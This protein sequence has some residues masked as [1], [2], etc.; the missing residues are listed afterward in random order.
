VKEVTVLTNIKTRQGPLGADPRNHRKNLKTKK[1]PTGR[2]RGKKERENKLW[3]TGPGTNPESWSKRFD[4]G[5]PI[6]KSGEGKLSVPEFSLLGNLANP[7]QEHWRLRGVKMKREK[8]LAARTSAN[9]RREEGNCL[10]NAGPF[11]SEKPLLFSKQLGQNRPRHVVPAG[12]DRFGG[13][14]RQRK[15]RKVSPKKRLPNRAADQR[16]RTGK[17]MPNT[18]RG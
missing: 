9:V 16:K 8:R 10:A 7:S 6:E 2:G 17:T 4:P 12:E 11:S 18:T 13:G 14:G 3:E 5:G 15:T 1:T